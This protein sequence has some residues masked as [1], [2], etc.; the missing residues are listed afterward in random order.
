MSQ[1]IQFAG[2]FLKSFVHSTQNTSG[3]PN[4]F[5]TPLPIAEAGKRRSGLIIQ[6]QH[7][8]ATVSICL[9]DV[10][11]TGIILSPLSSFSIDNYNGPVRVQS[12]T[13]NVPVHIAY[14]YA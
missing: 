2:P 9:S 12:A 7:A 1:N 3:T 6:N 8:T 14:S 10:G 11:T 5:T 13:A 4:T